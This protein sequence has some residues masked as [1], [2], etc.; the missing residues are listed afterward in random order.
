MPLPPENLTVA[1]TGASGSLFLKQFLLTIDLERAKALGESRQ[2][3]A[4]N[5]QLRAFA[6]VSANSTTTRALMP[7]PMRERRALPR[8]AAA[9]S[10]APTPIP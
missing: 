9:S 1:T 4:E 6:G 5:A 8:S 7:A 2:L 3:E 10:A